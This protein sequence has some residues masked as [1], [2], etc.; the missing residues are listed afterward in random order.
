MAQKTTN[1]RLGIVGGISIL[2]TTGIVQ[3]MST[4][5]WRASVL[6]AID[7]AVANGI[8]HLILTTGERTEE[9]AMR[10]FPL[11]EMAFVEMG[12]F[13][14]DCLRRAARKGIPRVTI[15][16]MIGKLAKVAA[17]QLQTHV[18]GGGVDVQFLAALARTAGLPEML[19][20]EI[21][22]ANSARH[23]QDLVQQAQPN[24]GTAFFD[25]ICRQAANACA[26]HA[27]GTVAVGVLLFDPEGT[28]LGQFDGR[29]SG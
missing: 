8:D 5:A 2:G 16:G 13:T 24:A 20:A 15:C 27:S 29:Q 1:P 12:I 19:T 21:G 10:R 3:A 9:F 26:G 7:V 6:Q 25:E 18:A 14:G 23:A 4:A 17:G 22:H 11:P 28:L